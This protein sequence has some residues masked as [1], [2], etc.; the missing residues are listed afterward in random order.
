MNE[1]R[2][3][4]ESSRLGAIFIILAL[5]LLVFT[6]SI[7]MVVIAH[8]SGHYL[9]LRQWGLDFQILR[10]LH[11]FCAIS[12]IFTGGIAVVF[13]FLFSV[14]K[15]K[16][17]HGKLEKSILGRSY[18]QLSL[19]VLAGV[20]T[21]YF[22]SQGDFT[23]REY[24][25]FKPEISLLIFLGW[26]LYASS[27]LQIIGLRLSKQPVYVWMWTTGLFLFMITFGEAHL[28]LLDYFMDRPVR[29]IAIQW[30]SYGALI[31]SMNLVV[32][33]SLIYVSEKISNDSSYAYSKLAFSLFFL[34]ILNSFTNFAHHTYHLPQSNLVQSISF[35]ISMLEI[36]ILF[37]VLLDLISIPGFI[38]QTKN[39]KVTTLLI[40]SVTF[41]TC[42]QL[43]L[44]IL[45]S[46]PPIN[47]LIH[48]TFVVLAHSIGTMVG[49]DTLA[50][51]AG[52]SYL[53]GKTLCTEDSR[54][55][56]LSVWFLNLGLLIL[57][58]AL[59]YQGILASHDRYVLSRLPSSLTIKPA[60][61]ILASL[62]GLFLFAGSIGL[63]FPW[64]TQW[65]KKLGHS[66]ERPATAS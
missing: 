62:G 38:K 59:L 10:P 18:L 54:T 3:D 11:T 13:S 4:S 6:T 24:I 21:T 12:F 52:M 36:I 15:Q 55:A 19:W 40:A 57:W 61:L 45:I 43:T 60:I 56:R 34:G 5:I 16:Y 50:I 32:Y 9:L 58:G 25:V 27:F 22:L 66:F 39:Y 48:G 1:Q 23:G 46:I 37:K 35:V 14:I 31:G 20:L 33:G 29:D 64:L 8:Y 44:S 28:Y 30:K 41:W 26:V 53:S 65:T 51:L 7:G 49:I 63:A 47:A 2:L 42:L 17:P